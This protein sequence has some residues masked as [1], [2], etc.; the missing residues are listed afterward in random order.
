MLNIK[1]TEDLTES[2]LFVKWRETNCAGS[3]GD[4]AVKLCLLKAFFQTL[5]PFLWCLPPVCL[6][7]L[8]GE[9]FLYSG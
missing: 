1:G 4:G 5:Q 2:L 3:F 8:P 7:P 9:L 6:D